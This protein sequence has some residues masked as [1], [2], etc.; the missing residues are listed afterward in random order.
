MIGQQCRYYCRHRDRRACDKQAAIIIQRRS[1]EPN[2]STRQ[3][4]E[5][6]AA[7][8]W[9]IGAYH[10]SPRIV[11]TG[12]VDAYTPTTP[13]QPSP[14]ATRR[15]LT[16]LSPHGVLL[17]FVVLAA[18]CNS[19]VT[20]RACCRR[21]PIYV[22]DHHHAASLLC[23]QRYRDYFWYVCTTTVYCFFCYS[24]QHQL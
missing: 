19:V 11:R 6:E 18:A 23:G 5:R 7:H 2:S 9:C 14:S 21:L 22:P 20:T 8:L 24:R 17:S 16:T 3:H 13:H 1:P 10:P 15:K 12:G 4:H